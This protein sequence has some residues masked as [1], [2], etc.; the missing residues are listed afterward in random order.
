MN[1]CCAF[2]IRSSNVWRGWV[3]MS[4][5]SADGLSVRRA[6]KHYRKWAKQQ[7]QHSSNGKQSGVSHNVSSSLL[8]TSAQQECERQAKHAARSPVKHRILLTW[9]D[10]EVKRRR[11]ASRCGFLL[12]SR[13]ARQAQNAQS[14]TLQTSRKTHCRRPPGRPAA[15]CSRLYSWPT[16]RRWSSCRKALHCNRLAERGGPCRS[17]SSQKPKAMHPS[18]L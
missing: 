1:A 11:K 4:L 13:R 18:S 10:G 6:W 8:M 5:V 15:V 14:S 17:P 12:F 9:C 7:R 3:P 2:R 16:R